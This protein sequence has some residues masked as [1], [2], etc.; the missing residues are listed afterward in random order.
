MKKKQNIF[1]ELLV[2]QR[3][4]PGLV[5]ALFVLAIVSMNLLA[6]K[7]I[8]LP[9]DWLALDCGFI[10]SW[11]VFL[12]MDVITKSFGP[13]AATLISVQALIVNLFVVFMLFLGAHIPG[14]W[15]ESFVEGS[16]EIINTALDHTFG[17]TWYVLLGSSIAFLA[18]SV[19]N[20]YVNWAI[21]R[22]LKIDSFG[23]FALRSYVSTF[24]GQFCD[25]LLFALIVSLHFFGWSMLQCFTCALTGAVAELL[26]EVI[27]SPIGY[28][29]A[30]KWKRENVGRE[31]FEYCKQ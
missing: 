25:N 5:L 29:V 2:L 19:V 13:R 14:I 8:N 22:S 30:A 7:S 3:S 1:T 4:V 12:L 11:L 23:T 9:V 24:V 17:G 10:F 28:K 21:G 16:E 6:N 27:F 31:Y 15:G 26:C 18:S 20:N